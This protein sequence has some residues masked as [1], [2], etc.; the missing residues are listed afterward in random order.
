MDAGLIAAPAAEGV[1]AAGAAVGIAGMGQ[2]GQAIARRLAGFEAQI[3]YYDD[4][5]LDARTE[6]TLSASCQSLEQLAESSDV[7]I[8]AL[9]LTSRTRHTMTILRSAGP[10]KRPGRCNSPAAS[11]RVASWPWPRASARRCD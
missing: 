4:R 5:R 9:P 3:A 6:E 2:L 8:A 10:S 11:G 1:A 7:L